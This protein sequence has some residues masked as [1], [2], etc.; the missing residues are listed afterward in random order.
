[1]A[2][3]QQVI[4]QARQLLSDFWVGNS[5]TVN[6]LSKRKI[7]VLGRMEQDSV[8]F[9]HTAQGGV[10]FKTHELFISGVIP[11]IFSVCLIVDKWNLESKTLYEST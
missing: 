9:Y 10:P 11:L 8:R 7:H 2:T 3:L 5:Y 4:W 1:M 6:I